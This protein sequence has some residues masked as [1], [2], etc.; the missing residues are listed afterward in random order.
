MS[1]SEPRL[2]SH[3]SQLQPRQPMIFVFDMQEPEP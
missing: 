1:E 3:L 2:Q